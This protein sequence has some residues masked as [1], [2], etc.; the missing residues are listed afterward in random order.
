MTLV[1]SVAHCSF[2]GIALTWLER[3]EMKST[4]QSVQLLEETTG[5]RLTATNPEEILNFFFELNSEYLNGKLE[6]C[7]SLHAI[8][9]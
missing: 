4:E 3:E 5:Y 6:N 1:S 8:N 2:A 7:Y 9:F